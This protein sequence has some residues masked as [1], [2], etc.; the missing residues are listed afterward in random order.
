MG[1]GQEEVSTSRGFRFRLEYKWQAESRLDGVG[2]RVQEEEH[3]GSHRKGQ[4]LPSNLGHLQA[5]GGAMVQ[6][7]LG[8]GVPAC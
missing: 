3:P 1:F 5:Q 6:E 4:S 8:S 2:V 7:R